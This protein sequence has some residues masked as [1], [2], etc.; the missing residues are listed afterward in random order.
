VGLLFLAEFL[1]DRQYRLLPLAAVAFGLM[2]GYKIAAPVHSLVAL[3][4]FAVL[5]WFRQRSLFVDKQQRM[6]LLKSA[7]LSVIIM[8]LISGYWYL[9]NLL[10]YGR[11]QGAYGMKL[12]ETGERLA[13]NSGALDAV[14]AKI[15]RASSFS[16]NLA[17]FFPRVFDYKNFYGADLVGISGYGPQFAAFGL[18]ALLAAIAAFF[19]PNWRK[20]PVF[21]FSS[22]AVLLFV[23]LMFVNFNANSY[24]ILSFF[25]VI[26]I[27]YAGVQLFSHGMLEK[28]GDVVVVNSIIVV[29]M[30][31]SLFILL[32][33]QYTNF[34]RFKE[35]ISLDAGQRT[36]A[37]YTRWFIVQ[38]PEFYR[39]MDAIPVSEPIAHVAYRGSYFPGES[40][41][42]T[43]RYLYMDRHWQR[44][45]YSL[46]L[47]EYFDCQENGDC[48]AKPALKAFLREN[49]VSLLSSCKINH[50]LKIRDKQLFEIMPGLYY[51][52][53]GA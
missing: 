51:F 47:P 18:L 38:R 34:L 32:P 40:A 10:V 11:L 20:Q 3:L 29:S 33:P 44:K 36:S 23:M 13:T 8:V 46:H 24:R 2:L 37:N 43:W 31:W 30:L 17:E 49:K 15:E 45:V 35:F 48:S 53:E 1:K 39:L 5:C 14:A 52:K 21:L 42:D 25:P 4:V 41:A 22:V 28:K 26:L 9:R 50:C 19:I 27:A 7:G 6:A 12:T 16:S